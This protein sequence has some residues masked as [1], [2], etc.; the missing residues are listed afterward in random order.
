TG[1]GFGRK[2]YGRFLSESAVIVG[3]PELKDVARR[4][5]DTAA[6]WS[7]LVT[8][9]NAAVKCDWGK[10]EFAVDRTK[11]RDAVRGLSDLADR[12]TA[13]MEALGRWSA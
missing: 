8:E 6:R 7:Q 2:L 3:A 10:R 11:V 1:G 5:A 4:F 9:L 12:E 13:Q